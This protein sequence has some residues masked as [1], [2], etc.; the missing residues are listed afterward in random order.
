MGSA[1]SFRG[2]GYA[3]KRPLDLLAAGLLLILASPF[4]V[5][6]GV[7]AAIFQGFP[8]LFRQTRPGLCGRP[9]ELVKFRTMRQGTDTDAQRLTRLG[10]F[11]RRTSLDE[12]PAFW[13]VLRGD[14]SL[15]GPRPLLMQYLD[16]YT[17]EQA[18][19][20][21]VKPGITGW[22]QVNGRNAI[23]WEKRFALD[24]WYVDHQSPWLDI[25]IILLTPWKVLRREGISQQ[26][27]ATMEEFLGADRTITA[28]AT[29]VTSR[30]TKERR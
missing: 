19:R 24:V 14:M 15:V 12:L 30:S 6:I 16:R 29:D 1:G 7:A 8:V 28:R 18:R 3:L 11:L 10:R 5:L 27:Q 17:P 22:A 13:N 23:G 20:H 21:E 25:K 26:G 4:L 2:T 9:F